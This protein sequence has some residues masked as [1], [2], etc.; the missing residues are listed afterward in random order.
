[1]F[2][3]NTKEIRPTSIFNA[4]TYLTPCS[5]ISIVNFEQVNVDWD[6]YCDKKIINTPYRKLPLI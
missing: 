3:V 2:K 4:W 6:A 1:M 5:S